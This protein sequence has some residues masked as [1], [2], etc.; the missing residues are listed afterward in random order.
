MPTQEDRMRRALECVLLFHSGSGF[1]DSAKTEAWF[2]RT[3]RR[4][5]TTKVLCDAVRAALEPGAERGPKLEYIG[6]AT[7]LG[8]VARYAREDDHDSIEMALVDFARITGMK[9]TAM[10][11]GSFN[12]E[13]SGA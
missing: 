6:V 2:A 13:P 11:D 3:G 7:L 9:V 8:Q 1:W 4:E 12:V 10:R 5:A